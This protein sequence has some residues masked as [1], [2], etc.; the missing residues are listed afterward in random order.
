MRKPDINSKLF[1][2]AEDLLEAELLDTVAYL[3]FLISTLCSIRTT[4]DKESSVCLQNGVN[5]GFTD[6]M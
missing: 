3:H 5:Q 6:G 4:A 1:Q 2:G